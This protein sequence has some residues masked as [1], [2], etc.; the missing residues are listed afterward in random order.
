MSLLRRY[1]GCNPFRGGGVKVDLADGGYN[2]EGDMGMGGMGALFLIATFVV[3]SRGCCNPGGGG[4]KPIIWDP[5]GGYGK[6]GFILNKYL[7]L[8]Y[9]L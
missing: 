3:F 5:P 9:N 8:F 4:I 1:G 2:L 6:P 7:Q